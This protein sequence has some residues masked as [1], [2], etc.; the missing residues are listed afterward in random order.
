MFKKIQYAMH[1][2]NLCSYRYII[3]EYA[4]NNLYQESFVYFHSW[5]YELHFF[6]LTGNWIQNFSEIEKLY[7][8]VL[9]KLWISNYMIM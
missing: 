3:I 6:L 5:S 8:Y 1:A 7:L 4:K 9:E 2:E